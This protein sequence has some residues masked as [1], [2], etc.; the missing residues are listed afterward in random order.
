[1]RRQPTGTRI[2]ELLVFAAIS[3]PAIAYAAGGASAAHGNAPTGIGGGFGLALLFMYVTRRN[4]IGGWLLYYYITA[5]FAFILNVI[6]LVAGY[7]SFASSNWTYSIPLATVVI[8]Y[9]LPSLARL[10]EIFAATW[11]LSRRTAQNLYFLRW[12]LVASVIVN[13][14]A[15]GFEYAFRPQVL[16]I[17]WLSFISVGL[18]CAYFWCSQRVKAV[19]IEKNWNYETFAQKGPGAR[20][21][22]ESNTKIE[23]LPENPMVSSP[24]EKKQAAMLTEAPNKPFPNRA[25]KTIIIV[26]ILLAIVALLF[27]PFLVTVPVDGVLWSVNHGFHSI[28]FSGSSAEIVNAKLLSIEL[29]TIAIVSAALCLFFRRS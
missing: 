9:I 5:Y 3:L 1:M 12:T 23:E 16:P 8:A 25:Q 4:A 13:G 21:A 2:A 18:W 19:F 14:A 7:Q 26:A 11:L 6:E 17:G 29:V 27:P 15:I 22:F 24:S 10:I 20:S 28:F